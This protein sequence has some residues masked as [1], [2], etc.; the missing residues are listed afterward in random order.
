MSRMMDKT[1]VLLA[2]LA[3]FLGLTCSAKEPG[4]IV[5]GYSMPEQIDEFQIT[6]TEG[7][8]DEAKELG[9]ELILLDSQN[10]PAKQA[11][12]MEDLIVM[13]VDLILVAPMDADAIVPSII[14]A[15]TANI[16]VMTMDRGANG[17]EVLSHSAVDNYG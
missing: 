12:D 16:P 8:Q 14:K 9:I 3:L 10:D 6:L 2:V 15:N 1:V 5:I 11:S 7:L 4:K 13:G 17:G